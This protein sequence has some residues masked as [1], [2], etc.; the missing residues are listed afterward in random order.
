[1]PATASETLY[2]LSAF[3]A[4]NGATVVRLR[5]AFAWALGGLVMVILGLGLAA[6]LV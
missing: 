5:L 2:A 6:A 4:D 3:Q 1:M